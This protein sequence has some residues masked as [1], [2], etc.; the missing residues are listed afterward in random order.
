MMTLYFC[1]SRKETKG[2]YVI[3]PSPK[4]AIHKYAHADRVSARSVQARPANI[5]ID[6][7]ETE[8]IDYPNSIVAQIYGIEYTPEERGRL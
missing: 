1:H 8:C 3:A 6:P 7:D 5:D 4:R 2:L